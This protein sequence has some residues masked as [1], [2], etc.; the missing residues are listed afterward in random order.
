MDS[1]SDP[2]G[3]HLTPHT[4]H[5]HTQ[6]KFAHRLH[7]GFPTAVSDISFHKA[8]YSRRSNAET[9]LAGTS[10]ESPEQRA[11]GLLSPHSPSPHKS[12]SLLLLSLWLLLC[13]PVSIHP[14]GPLVCKGWQFMASCLGLPPRAQPAPQSASVCKLSYLQRIIQQR[15]T[16][17][18]TE[19]G[20]MK[21]R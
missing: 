5:S 2:M 13:F 1:S 12:R 10:E 21:D 16:H 7:S 19:G 20:R 9:A 17:E 18:Y 15:N 6:T 11:C 8:I 14:A 4:P 3:P